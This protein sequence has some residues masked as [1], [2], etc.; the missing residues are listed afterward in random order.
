V[1]YSFET[2]EVDAE[3]DLGY[4][5]TATVRDGVVHAIYG[6][7]EIEVET[8]EKTVEGSQLRHVS[9][10]VDASISE[11][12]PE[13]EVVVSDGPPGPCNGCPNGNKCATDSG[14]CLA[15]TDDCE[16]DCGDGKSCLEGSCKAV[17]SEPGTP[18]HRLMTGLYPQI[19]PTSDDL[20]VVFYN[21][22]D[23]QIGWVRGTTGSWGD[24]SYVDRE[25]PTGP[26]ADAAV[27]GNGKL[28]LAYM[29]PDDNV[30]CYQPPGENGTEVIAD[31]KRD[32]SN[33]YLVAAIGEDVDLRLDGGPP[34]ATFQDATT[35]ALLQANRSGADNWSVTRLSKSG[36]LDDYKGARGFYATNTGPDGDVVVEHVIDQQVK[37]AEARLEFKRL[38]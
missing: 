32:R 29:D 31:G 21:H 2:I 3:T 10:P 14:T 1:G 15:A 6:V 23:R 11:L 37:P 28:H 35:H 4:Y 27:D 18:A 25:A 8:G 13:P 38:E 9:F 7:P 20:V 34:H 26:Y 33:E 22:N 36:S 19:V 5:T 16:S 12:S 30:L 17:Y 24:P